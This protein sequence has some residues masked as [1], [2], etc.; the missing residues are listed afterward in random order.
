[1]SGFF[2]KGDKKKKADQEAAAQ[3]VEG[4]EVQDDSTAEEQAEA[5][6]SGAG[7]DFSPEAEAAEWKDKY[8]RALAEL[9][10][11]RKRTDAHAAPMPRDVSRSEV[12]HARLYCPC[13]T[14]LQHACCAEGDGE[15]IREGVKLAQHDSAPHPRRKRYDR[16]RGDG[17]DRSIR[18]C[19]KRWA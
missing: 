16:D 4:E 17:A 12:P 3:H 18:G 14:R 15:A 7:R 1:M 2:G 19:T 8:V 6:G 10:N 13:S 5:R 11:F 9:E